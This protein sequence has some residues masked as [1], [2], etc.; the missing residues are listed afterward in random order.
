MES[1]GVIEL[2]DQGGKRRILLRPIDAERIADVGRHPLAVALAQW[3]AFQLSTWHEIASWYGY[4]PVPYWPEKM[5][6]FSPEDLYSSLLGIKLAGGILLFHDTSDDVEYDRAMNAWIE[7]AFKR[8]QVT[9]K[10]VGDRSD[11]CRRRAMVGLEPAPSRLA[12]PA[13]AKLRRRPVARTVAGLDWRLLRSRAPPSAATTPARRFGCGSPSSFEGRALRAR[14]DLGDRRRGRGSPQTGSP[15]HTEGTA[16]SREVLGSSRGNHRAD[17]ARER[18]GLRARARPS[19]RLTAK[20][21]KPAI[22]RRCRA[23]RVHLFYTQAVC[24]YRRS[25]TSPGIFIENGQDLSGT[26]HSLPVHVG[27][28]PG[29]S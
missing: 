6:A 10:N 13:A 23:R 4:A 21:R 14:R 26:R 24:S 28:L 18:S 2:A 25:R 12:D 11:P 17:P 20:R 1:G 27:N 29:G 15:S 19:G 16:A 3:L 7:M 8:M 5:S 9:A 22:L